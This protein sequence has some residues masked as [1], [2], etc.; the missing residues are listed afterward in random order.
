MPS[1]LGFQDIGS[2]CGSL[3]RSL[4]LFG[5]RFSRNS[6]P[7]EGSSNITGCRCEG[8][9]LPGQRTELGMSGQVK[10]DIWVDA[11]DMCLLLGLFLNRP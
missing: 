6:Q 3:S 9:T 1:G 7:Q 2:G 10:I 5:A 11:L 4:S 8:V